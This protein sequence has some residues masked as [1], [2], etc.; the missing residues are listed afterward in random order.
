MDILVALLSQKKHDSLYTDFRIL[1]LHYGTVIYFTHAYQI[2]ECV[3]NTGTIF[4]RTG[5]IERRLMNI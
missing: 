2:I 1:L 4:Q 3:S 5:K